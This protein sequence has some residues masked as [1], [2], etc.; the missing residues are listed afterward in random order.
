MAGHCISPADHSQAV[1]SCEPPLLPH[2]AFA[3]QRWMRCCYIPSC[4]PH[5]QKLSI[6]TA[7]LLGP[8]VW[9]PSLQLLRSPIGTLF[10]TPKAQYKY[11]AFFVLHQTLSGVAQDKQCL[12]LSSG[13]DVTSELELQITI[14]KL[15][16]W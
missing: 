3:L 9:C 5:S 6:G 11:P 12:K 1:G 13:N 7:S 10:F 14:G 16:N 2:T 8:V 4:I 15:S